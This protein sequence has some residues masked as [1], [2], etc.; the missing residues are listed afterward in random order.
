MAKRQCVFN[1]VCPKCSMSPRQFDKGSLAEGRMTKAERYTAVCNVVSR[2]VSPK[3][4]IHKSQSFLCD[5][6]LAQAHQQASGKHNQMPVAVKLLCQR[7]LTWVHG[8]KRVTGNE[9][10]DGMAKKNA[11]AV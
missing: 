1:A 5:N 4:H 8:Q 7:E 2:D 9:E 6:I 11:V 10:V 3:I